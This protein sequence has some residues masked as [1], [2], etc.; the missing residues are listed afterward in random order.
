MP[1][2]KPYWGWK[3]SQPEHF[4]FLG[5]QLNLL[6]LAG[7]QALV[8]IK[9]QISNLSTFLLPSPPVAYPPQD[10]L[11]PQGQLCRAEWFG[12]I[13]IHPHAES[14]H[15]VHFVTPRGEDNDGYIM[16]RLSSEMFQ[17]P[18]MP[19]IIMSRITRSAN[20]FWL[21]SR[22]SSPLAAVMTSK[23]SLRS[24]CRRIL[25]YFRIVVNS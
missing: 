24:V 12:L 23:P 5:S 4:K 6:V 21:F 10:R 16:Q 15:P 14:Y 3:P 9:G 20:I 17:K 1:L 22:A 13:I 18:S 25:S 2:R 7:Y 19:G 11:D 8:V